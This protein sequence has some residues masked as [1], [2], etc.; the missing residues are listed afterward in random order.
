M[1]HGKVVLRGTT[2]WTSPGKTGGEAFGCEP[3]QSV[4][5]SRFTVMAVLASN[6]SY[7]IVFFDVSIGGQ[8]RGLK[9]GV[10]RPRA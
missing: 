7:P 1:V 10:R 9:V 5:G 6:L 2:S 3:A 8:V 4:S